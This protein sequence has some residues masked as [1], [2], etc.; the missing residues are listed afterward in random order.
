MPLL[1][2]YLA[3]LRQLHFKKDMLLI[4]HVFTMPLFSPIRYR[5]K[6]GVLHRGIATIGI[7]Q[8]AAWAV[9]NRNMGVWLKVAGYW[10]KTTRYI[11][12]RSLAEV[13]K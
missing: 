13:R 5:G 2:T 11:S 8:D 6:S 12:S 3:H 4:A 7:A 9:Q 1:L 10:L